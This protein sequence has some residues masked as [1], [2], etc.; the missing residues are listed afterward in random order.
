LKAYLRQ[1]ASRRYY[2]GDG[3]W[4]DS[5]RH[6]VVFNDI[7]SAERKAIADALTDVEVVLIDRNFGGEGIIPLNALI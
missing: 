1:T 5:I 3:K 6:A 7:A 2:A 4:A